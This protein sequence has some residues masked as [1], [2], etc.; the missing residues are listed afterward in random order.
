MRAELLVVAAETTDR[1]RSAWRVRAARQLHAIGRPSEAIELLRERA[2]DGPDDV[3]ALAASILAGSLDHEGEND[4]AWGVI[5]ASRDL[6]PRP[7]SEGALGLAIVES[8]VLVNRGRLDAGLE[9]AERAAAGPADPAARYRLDGHLAAIRLYA[10]HTSDVAPLTRAID[11]AISAE[12]GGV[13][14]GR[15]MDLYYLTLA[16]RGAAAARAVAFDLAARLDAIGYQT[17]ATEL[18]AECAQA[19][20]LAG[21]LAGTV[22]LVDPMLEEPLGL[23][24]RQRLLYNRGL[25]LGLLG[26]IDDAERTFTEVEP[27]ASDSFDGRGSVLWCQA[28]VALWSGRPLRALELATTSLTFTAFNDAE[29]VLPAL[30][31]A[32]AEVEVGQAPSIDIVTPSFPALH[33]API[34]LGGL[35]ALAAGRLVDAA[36]AFDEAAALW[37]GYHVPRE[38]ICRWAGGEALRLAGDTAAIPRLR[39]ALDGASSIGFEP[40][41]ARARRSLRLAGERPPAAAPRTRAGALLTGRE[42]ESS[43]SWRVGSPTPRSHAG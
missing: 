29:Y 5:D 25:A 40:L 6:R 14:A 22:V 23:L 27:I 32:W 16:L 28:E 43:I 37:A 1:D 26:R 36:M 34:E 17:R 8:V 7:G 38:H 9:V 21:D 42:R 10:G 35:R 41:A 12:D 20:I 24:S 2:V 3:R 4:E 30:V 39:V 19:S 31:R 11:A 13:A 33:G 15:A 18:R